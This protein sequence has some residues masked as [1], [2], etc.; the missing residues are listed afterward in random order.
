VSSGVTEAEVVEEGIEGAVDLSVELIKLCASIGRQDSVVSDGLESRG[1]EW[2][3]HA[4]G[5]L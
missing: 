1:G 3:V 5:E 4:M 2:R